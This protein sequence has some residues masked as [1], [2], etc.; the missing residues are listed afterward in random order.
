MKT[1]VIIG[2]FLASCGQEP[3]GD[4]KSAR[5]VK[6]GGEV[7]TKI[8]AILDFIDFMEEEKYKKEVRL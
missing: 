3:T 6:T 2:L 5:V 8:K 1:I 4:V 7:A